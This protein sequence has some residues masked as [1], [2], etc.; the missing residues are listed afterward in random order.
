MY[1][2]QKFCPQ[3]AVTFR[4][5]RTQPPESA[6]KTNDPHERGYSEPRWT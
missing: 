5:V 3:T 4:V 1:F 6:K 2:P